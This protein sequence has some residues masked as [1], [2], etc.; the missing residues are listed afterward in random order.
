MQ[1]VNCIFLCN[2]CHATELIKTQSEA[3]PK[4]SHDKLWQMPQ[5]PLCTSSHLSL[6]SQKNRHLGKTR[7]RAHLIL[8]TVRSHTARLISLSVE[9]SLLQFKSANGGLECLCSAAYTWHQIYPLEHTG[10]C[11]R[12]APIHSRPGHTVPLNFQASAEVS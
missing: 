5:D 6:Q 12:Q 1:V 4:S 9:H 11:R 7:I 10:V 8:K 3:L 2:V